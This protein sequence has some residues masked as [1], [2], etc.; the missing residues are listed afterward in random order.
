MNGSLPSFLSV[1]LLASLSPLSAASSATN[2]PTPVPTQPKISSSAPS[3]T[4]S[5]TN[6]QAIAA[7]S[8]NTPATNATATDTNLATL[9]VR[10]LP[11]IH[12]KISIPK[13]WTLLPGKLLEGDVLLATKEKVT[14]ENDLWTTGLSMTVDRNGPKD[15]GQK[16]SEYARA[17]A[18]EAQ[19]KAGEEATP[20]KESQSGGL[21]EFRFEFPVPADTPLTVTEV[22]RANDKTGDLFVIL[23]Q[24]PKQESPKL[25]DLR[26]AVLSS[27]VLGGTTP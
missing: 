7:P 9:T 22:L 24:M 23:W 4:V 2:S 12:G 20:I 10:D 14:C 3:I 1:A 13:D 19:E 17:L 27:L 21:Q 5:A 6:N 26:E 25:L 8:T 16:P 15:S 11:E 18:R